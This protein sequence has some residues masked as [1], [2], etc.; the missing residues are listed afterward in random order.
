MRNTSI[1]KMAQQRVSSIVSQWRLRLLGHI[2]HMDDHW[3][4]KQL[5]VSAPYGGSRAVGGQKSHWND[6]VQ[7]D[8]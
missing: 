4:P 5:L 7:R 1:R 2:V 3:L 8:L 6:L